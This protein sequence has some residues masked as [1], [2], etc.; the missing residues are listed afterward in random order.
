M[1]DLRNGAKQ[2][3]TLLNVEISRVL[4]QKTLHE[5]VQTLPASRAALK[6]VKGMGGTR[7]QQ[8]GK[9]ILEQVI[10]YRRQKGLDLPVG[11]EKEVETAG[12]SSQEISFKLFQSGQSIAEIAKERSMA[13]STIEGH[14]ALYVGTGELELNRL[15]E[16]KKT[17]AILACIEKQKIRGMNE[18]RSALGN[19]YSYSEIRFVLKHLEAIG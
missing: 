9:E 6:A 19:D 17:K 18:L 10:A 15:V 2:K 3:L 4:P 16:P 14:L 11:A 1:P 5:I 12:M 13:V 7:M 8:V